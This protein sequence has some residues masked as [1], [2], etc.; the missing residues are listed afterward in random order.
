[1]TTLTAALQSTPVVYV[2]R[3]I[4]RAFGLPLDTKNYYVITNADPN[5]QRSRAP[6]NILYIKENAKL[7][8]RELLTHPLAVPFI[9]AIQ[10]RQIL[11]FKNTPQIEKICE[12]NGWNLLNPPAA[13]ASF[14]EEKI[15]QLT[16]LGELKKFLPPHHIA[17]CK[18]LVW[19]KEPYIVQFNRAHTGSGTLLITNEE[20]INE[21]KKTFPDRE[22]RVTTFIAG[23]AFTNNNVVWGKQVLCGNINYQITGLSPFTDQPFA[24]VGNDWALPEK[25]LSK[26]QLAKYFQMATAIGRQLA[27]SGWKGLFGIDTMLDQKTGKLYLIEINARQPASTAYESELQR[28]QGRTKGLTTFEAHLASL[29]GVA[30]TKQRLI[31]I[32]D[33]AQI[34]QRV[35]PLITTIN[36]NTLEKLQLTKARIIQYNNKESGSDLLRI[37]T[38]TGIL[39]RPNVFNWLGTQLAYACDTDKHRGY[40]A[41]VIFIKNKRLLLMKKIRPDEQFYLITGGKP[42]E[43]ETLLEAA[44]REAAEETSLRFTIDKNHPPICLQRRRR[45]VYFFAKNIYGTPQLGGPELAKIKPGYQYL[46]EWVDKKT[47][48]RLN[49]RQVELKPL[50]ASLL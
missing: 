3:D 31:T 18:N 15:S 49:L 38:K 9:N 40:R 48:R 4:E 12:T 25:I 47:L 27:T 6:K 39:L 42:E 32:N 36:K 26:Q 22:V 19:K 43:K 23:P 46:L 35:T 30:P 8:T 37:Q 16:W 21:L 2:T 20:Q 24:T 7:D 11:V 29:L 45:E 13:L 10:N 17:L 50:L 5:N 28:T 34:V 44:I 1:M 14:V 41:G 33:G